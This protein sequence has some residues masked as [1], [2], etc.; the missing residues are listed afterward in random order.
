MRQKDWMFRLVG[1]EM[2]DVNN[3]QCTIKVEPDG[4][5]MYTY[6]LL[7]DGKSLEDFCEQISKNRSTWIVTAA[8]GVE[9][10]IVHGNTILMCCNKI[11]LYIC[12]I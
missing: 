3:V 4:L 9:N 1:D 10:R 7:V 8:D 2:F 11:K 6:S 5:F 12:I